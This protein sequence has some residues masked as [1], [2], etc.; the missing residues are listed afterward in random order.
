MATLILGVLSLLLTVVV[1]F[2][3]RFLH[4]GNR[5]LGALQMIVDSEVVLDTFVKGVPEN[6]DDKARVVF[7]LKGAALSTALFRAELKKEL[8]MFRGCPARLELY[9]SQKEAALF[10]EGKAAN[11]KRFGDDWLRTYTLPA[12]ERKASFQGPV[13]QVQVT[14]AKWEPFKQELKGFVSTV[15]APMLDST[16]PQQGQTEASAMAGTDESV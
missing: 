6:A 16:K 1:G 15:E 11:L 2:G 14:S 8:T 4:T 7:K 10:A 5:R 13:M 12:S 9:S 3:P